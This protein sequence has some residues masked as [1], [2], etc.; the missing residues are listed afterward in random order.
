M[1]ILTNFET[2]VVQKCLFI[3][4]VVIQSKYVITY[5]SNLRLA[6]W[7]KF[8]CAFYLTSYKFFSFSH[9]AKHLPS[10]YNIL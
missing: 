5:M 6:N 10:Y 9:A 2:V 7:M 3:T 1:I 4:L 8:W